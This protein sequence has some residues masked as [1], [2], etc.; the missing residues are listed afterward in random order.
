MSGPLALLFLLYINLHVGLQGGI[1][2]NLKCYRYC[3]IIAY[4][5]SLLVNKI[6]TATSYQPGYVDITSL[7]PLP[8]VPNVPESLVKR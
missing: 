3:M 7:A 4:N 8:L 6:K 5:L 1:V 2:M